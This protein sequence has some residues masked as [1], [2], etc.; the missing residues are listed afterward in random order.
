MFILLLTGCASK[1][2]EALSLREKLLNASLCSFQAEITADYG[3]TLCEFTLYCQ[4]DDKGDLAF[5]VAAPE[6]IQGITGNVSAGKG[7]LTF[8]GTG[9]SFPLLADGQLSPVSAPWV[10]L[11][12]M[13]SGYLTSSGKEGPLT[14]LTIDDSFQEDP[15]QAD[16]WLENG[17]PIRAELCFRGTKILSIQV[18]E[19]R[20]EGKT[21]A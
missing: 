18:R 1:D 21:A 14:R 8:D 15:L 3:D 20:T 6:S 16:I 17:I 7:K 19:F 4:S 5:T 10:M 11:R 2:D 12:A 9:L 13:R